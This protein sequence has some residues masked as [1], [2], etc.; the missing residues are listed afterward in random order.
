[1]KTFTLTMAAGFA[2]VALLGCQP[3]AS[4]KA[5]DA[6][7]ADIADAAA[8]VETPTVAT[9][10]ASP[11]PSP[12]AETALA[13][14]CGESI[15]FTEGTDTTTASGEVSGYDTCTFRLTGKA[16]QQLHATL[17]GSTFLTALLFAPTNPDMAIAGPSDK[18]D[19]TLPA[20]GEY[21]MRIGQVR[22]EARRSTS[23][24]TFKLNVQ[25]R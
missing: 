9:S 16:G 8:S 3:N 19:A 20:D 25:L 5:A 7:S 14:A 23:P 2:A 15:I 18:L 4:D 12:T 22:A 13:D 11:A 1:M 10:V 6:S 24:K 17:E 21:E